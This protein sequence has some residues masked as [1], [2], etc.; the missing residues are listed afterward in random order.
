MPR[1]V[2]AS[3]AFGVFFPAF[4]HAE[5]L[6]D[7][8]RKCDAAVG[9]TVPD[10]DCDAGSLVPDTHPNGAMCDRPN[11]LNKVC[12]PGSRFQV[13][14][15]GAGTSGAVIVAHCRKK[16]NPMNQD[17]YGDIAVIQYN[18]N[19]GATCFYQAL[20]NLDGHVKAPSKGTSAWPWMTPEHTANIHCGECHDNG[21]LIRSPYLAQL[22]ASGAKDVLPGPFN[23]SSPYKFVGDDFKS[24]KAFSVEISG[25]T[26]N[27]CHRMGVSNMNFNGRNGGDGSGTGREFGVMATA[28]SQPSKNPHSA[29][30]PIW[31]TPGQITFDQGNA[32]AAK[33]IHD[34]AVAFSKGQ[35][36]PSGC[37][38]NPFAGAYP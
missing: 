35:A 7:Y 12:D 37:N 9:M 21:P 13:L 25:N 17:K 11:V 8:A 22:A 34:C 24:W 31:M 18:K 3:L 30:S 2:L 4:A 15:K 20:Q 38:V 32:D 33:A 5:S 6:Q 1:W 26:C 10:F 14:A 29:D 16:G 28:P 23:T 36:L 27:D 19:N